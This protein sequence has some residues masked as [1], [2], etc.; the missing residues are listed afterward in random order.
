MAKTHKIKHVDGTFTITGDNDTWI[1]LKSAS[2]TLDDGSQ[3]IDI[4][5]SDDITVILRN[6]INAGVF[7]LAAQGDAMRIEI[8][9]G[10]SIKAGIPLYTSGPNTVVTNRGT[11]DA[12]SDQNAIYSEGLNYELRN[13]GRITNQNEDTRVAT[14][15]VMDNFA[16]IYNEKGGRIEGYIAVGAGLE[17]GETFTLVNRGLISGEARAF[18]GS[19]G[20]D[21]VVN[22]GKFAGFVDL[23]EGNDVIDTRGGTLAVPYVG[24]GSGDDLLI[25]DNAHYFLFEYDGGG[26]DMIMSTVSYGMRD[27]SY[28]ETLVLMGS[29]N[30]NATGSIHGEILAGNVGNNRIHGMGGHDRLYGDRGDD[31]LWGDDGS[32]TFIF[33]NGSGKDRIMDFTHPLDKIE[34]NSWHGLKSYDDVLDHASFEGG[35]MTIRAG[36]DEIA[37]GDFVFGN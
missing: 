1:F 21:V 36:K 25:T 8:D 13:F 28:V 6:R 4:A 16:H 18:Y 35:D 15:S 12:V 33:R 22:T 24:G 2:I 3:G 17:P 37:S 32:D 34:L 31:R 5:D 10:A 7:G 14:V 27:D 9:E 30:I 29:K 23:V 19:R 20:N 26:N 11:I